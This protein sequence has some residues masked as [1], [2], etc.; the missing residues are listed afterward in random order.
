[1]RQ[2]VGYKNDNSGFFTFGVITFYFVF[3]IDFMSAL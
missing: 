1:M 3:E 2:H